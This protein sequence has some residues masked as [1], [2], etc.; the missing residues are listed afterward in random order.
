METPLFR[1][2]FS[3]EALTLFAQDVMM[4]Y[5]K[6]PFWRYRLYAVGALLALFFILPGTL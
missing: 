1:N 3:L 5:R 2:G 4:R 6:L